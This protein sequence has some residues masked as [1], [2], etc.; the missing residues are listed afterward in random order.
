MYSIIPME[1]IDKKGI[2]KKS[3]QSSAKNMTGPGQMLDEGKVYGRPRTTGLL[4][5]VRR[6]TCTDPCGYRDLGERLRGGEVALAATHLS[7]SRRVSW[8]SWAKNG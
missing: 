2:K 4:E 3:T 7:A 6:K 5:T 1:I 8:V